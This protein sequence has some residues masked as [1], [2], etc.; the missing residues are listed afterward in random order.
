VDA[1]T[2]PDGYEPGCYL[3]DFWKYPSALEVIEVD[4][5]EIDPGI[6]EGQ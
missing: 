6:E 2:G 5:F 3:A 1:I 4:V